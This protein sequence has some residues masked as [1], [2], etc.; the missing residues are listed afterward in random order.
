MAGK[1]AKYSLGFT[2]IELLVVLAVMAVL[3]GMLGFSVLSGN[4]D[5]NSGQ[6]QILS[7]IH[8]TRTTALSTGQE[9]RL[10][11]YSDPAD[12]EKYMRF[13]SI[14]VREITPEANNVTSKDWRIV[15]EGKFLPDDLWYVDR[16]MDVALGWMGDA[17]S[18]WS[19]SEG[20]N[21]FKLGEL[22]NGLREESS[23]GQNS[24][25][26]IAFG[27]SGKVI[28]DDYPNMPKL[29]LASGEIRPKDGVLSP[30]LSNPQDVAGLK[31][32]PFGGMFC[33][34]FNDFLQNE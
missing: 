16:S 23:A 26:Y 5:I 18:V 1:L 22:K 9:A 17:F 21:S 24:Y 31:I 6:R 12:L 8:Q 7:M 30:Y 10:I 14:V 2:L 4:A 25:R 20:D 11:V 34:E 15:Q 33:L 3:M 28:S 13:S 27:P 19:T 29:V 32:M